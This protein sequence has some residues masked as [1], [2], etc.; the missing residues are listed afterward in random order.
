MASPHAAG[1]AALLV[2]ALTQSNRP[3]DAARVRQALVTT[4]Q[5]L[6]GLTILDQ[7]GGV[8]DVGR[9]WRWLEGVRQWSPLQGRAAGDVG[10]GS[11][12]AFR[13]TGLRSAGDTLQSFTLT[14]TDGATTPVELT[15][16]SDA[17]WLVAPAKLTL[18]GT[19]AT[20]ALRYRAAALVQPGSYVGTV[21]L[22]GS[23]T[24]A[25]PVARLV[26][27]VVVPIA[28]GHD[29]EVP[30][31]PVGAGLERRLAFGAEQGRPFEVRI[32]SAGERDVIRGY[33]HEPGGQP[34]RGGH[35]QEGSAGEE[36]IFFRVA[37]QDVTTGVYEAVAAA[38]PI[39]A[40]TAGIRITQA[41]VSLI[42]SFAD[43]KGVAALRNLT[44]APVTVVVGA[45]QIGATRLETVSGT[46]ADT[47]RLS[48]DI[49]PW[50]KRIEIDASMATADWPKFTDFGMTLE[51]GAGIQLGQGPLN[52]HVGRLEADLPKK[53][54]GNRGEL[55]LY[56]AWTVGGSRDQ[57]SLTLKIRMY[58]DPTERVALTATGTS[59]VTIP[60][61]TPESVSF[62]PGSSPW[63]LPA[64]F[65]PLLQYS[66]T[67]GEAAPWMAEAPLAVAP[68]PLMR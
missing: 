6:D 2:S 56:P 62:T 30:V 67:I 41:P 52:Y 20:V 47:G 55:R 21:T 61:G 42:G 49:P 11:N 58:G 34:F 29:F 46:G 48:F 7:G 40:S 28:G 31:A 25:G 4:A 16:R 14:R 50:V 3:V 43:G 17:S 45:A 10:R 22:W 9:A 37:A 32:T 57:W 39:L 33:L 54:S 53:F 5:P 23:D 19:S 13:P 1:L 15:L 27:G 65:I 38:P 8:P 51:D 60:A 26:N 35:E 44:E 24:M 66:A 12:S 63:P 59:T 18:R 36:A 68:T 64:G